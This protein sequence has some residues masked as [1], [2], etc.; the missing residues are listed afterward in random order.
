MSQTSKVETYK[1]YVDGKWVASRGRALLNTWR[2]QGADVEELIKEMNSD[3]D[4]Y[5]LGTGQMIMSPLV[6]DGE[7]LRIN[8]DMPNGRLLTT[9]Q[10]AAFLIS[11]LLTPKNRFR[12]NEADMPPCATPEMRSFIARIPAAAD[13]S[14]FDSAGLSMAVYIEDIEANSSKSVQ[15]VNAVRDRLIQQLRAQLAGRQSPS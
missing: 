2:S 8:E 10:G 14:G 4:S 15:F 9:S 13:L 7:R 5:R 3:L 11:I 6:L 1:N 12:L